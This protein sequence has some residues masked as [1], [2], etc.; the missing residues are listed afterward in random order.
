MPAVRS[1]VCGMIWAGAHAMLALSSEV[2]VALWWMMRRAR[3]PLCLSLPPDIVSEVVCFCF[4]GY[5]D[6]CCS[7]L[8][9]VCCT[10]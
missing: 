1:W 4:L 5:C 2:K 8:L 7:F 9:R 10:G 6:L 3:V